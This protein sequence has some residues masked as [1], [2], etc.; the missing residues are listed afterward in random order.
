MLAV[1]KKSKKFVDIAVVVWDDAS[2]ASY[3]GPLKSFKNGLTV[4]TAGVDVKQM[5]ARDRDRYV[6]VVSDYFPEIDE[7]RDFHS[8]PRGMVKRV[9]RIRVYF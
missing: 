7:V 9:K 8:I 4:V 5:S 2:K 6:A 3:Q 1:G